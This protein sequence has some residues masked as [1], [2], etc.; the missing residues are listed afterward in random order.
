MIAA[1]SW[2]ERST[3]RP[4][5]AVTVLSRRPARQRRRQARRRRRPRATRSR[6]VIPNFVDTTRI[7]PLA[8]RERATA[9]E[10]GLD[11]KTVV[12]YA[13][14]VGLLAVARAGARPRPRTATTRDVVFVINGGGSAL[15]RP[16]APRPRPDQRALRRHASPG[17]AA[18][19]ARGRPT[20]TSCRSSG[21]WPGPACRRSSTRSWPPGGRSW[22]ASI[23]AP[24]SPARSPAGAGLCVPPDDAEAFTKALRSLDRRPAGPAPRWARAGRR[25]VEGWVSPRAWPPLRR[26][27]R[28]AGAR[29]PHGEISAAA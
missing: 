16:R 27:V 4:S 3:Y 24:R 5:D 29:R 7:R 6:S 28:R 8:A 10:Y 12:M 19:G 2:L 17:A 14:N 22:P 11:G 26:P 20:C 25:F 13:G 23:P 1:A 15:P 9:R 21:A 18:R